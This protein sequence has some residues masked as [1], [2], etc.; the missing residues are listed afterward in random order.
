MSISSPPEFRYSHHGLVFYPL[1]VPEIPERLNLA[2]DK[3][4]ESSRYLQ[5]RAQG[6]VLLHWIQPPDINVPNLASVGIFAS[7]D[8]PQELVI[9]K[10]LPEISRRV[11]ASNR[12]YP[13]P[14]EVEQ[15]S[16]SDRDAAVHKR[17]IRFQMKTPNEDVTL[18]YKYYNGGTLRSFIKKYADAGRRVPEGFIW[19]VIAQL[20]QWEPICHQD[21]HVDNILLHFPTDEEK[22]A[23]PR[24]EQFDEYL[25][26][27]IITDFGLSFQA[28]NDRSNELATDLNPDLPEPTAWKDKAFIGEAILRLLIPDYSPADSDIQIFHPYG[29]FLEPGFCGTHPEEQMTDHYSEEL[30][31]CWS[32]FEALVPLQLRFEHW[33][34]A[35]GRSDLEQWRTWPPN[36]VVFGTTIAQADRHVDA[37]ISSSNK[38]SLRWTQ[39]FNSFM[40]YHSVF[41]N[42]KHHRRDW[43]T[44]DGHL[45][46]MTREKL[47]HFRPGCVKI[48]QAH[49]IGRGRVEKELD[50][51]NPETRPLWDDESTSG[52]ESSSSDSEGPVIQ[53]R[54]ATTRQPRRRKA[55][56]QTERSTAQ[57]RPTLRATARQPTR[58][59]Q[60]RTVRDSSPSVVDDYHRR[61]WIMK[62]DYERRCREKGLW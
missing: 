57:G 59:V 15:S 5:A 40:P 4:N 27:V 38:E 36:H 32:Q 13:M 16:L 44:V 33:L 60:P 30:V 37:Y 45:S 35:L 58:P 10:K 62:R 50:E 52:E 23:D 17:T 11:Q 7:V 47:A 55:P 29:G 18:F 3:D 56:R 53:A 9:I 42:P 19:H 46:A 48:R 51:V 12:D 49:I 61:R 22:E 31:Q 39:T 26:Q 14:A 25:P 6:F 21:L 41:R 8:Y 43:A 34:D 24:L 1:E 54:R 28:K 20:C 2:N